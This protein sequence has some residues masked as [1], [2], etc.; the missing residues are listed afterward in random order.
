MIVLNCYLFFLRISF[1]LCWSLQV[2]WLN[3]QL[4]KLWPFVSE[5]RRILVVAWCLFCKMHKIDLRLMHRFCSITINM[6][7]FHQHIV[8]FGSHFHVVCLVVL[9]VLL[10]FITVK[11]L[12]QPKTLQKQ[13]E[14]T[15]QTSR[16]THQ[17]ITHKNDEATRVT[18]SSFP[19]KMVCYVCCLP[20]HVVETT[21][22]LSWNLVDL[23]LS[24][25]P[26]SKDIL[27]VLEHT[28]TKEK[29]STLCWNASYIIICAKAIAPS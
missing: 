9:E 13:E 5:V 14:Q 23:C 6:K 1:C 15:L 4:S 28:H 26:I 18:N 27:N 19:C 11:I 16:N 21:P 10:L 3:K 17:K 29:K 2:K 24:S 7:S 12:F 22:Q 25:L 20:Q 8:K